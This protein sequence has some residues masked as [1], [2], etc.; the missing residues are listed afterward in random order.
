MS[1]RIIIATL[2][3]ILV[4]SLGYYFLKNNSL[5]T[6]TTENQEQEATEPEELE[7][8]YGDEI[9]DAEPS[10]NSSGYDPSKDIKLSEE[11]SVKSGNEKIIIPDRC[12]NYSIETNNKTVTGFFDDDKVKDAVVLE[13]IDTKTGELTIDA[14]QVPDYKQFIFSRGP[15]RFVTLIPAAKGDEILTQCGKGYKV[16]SKGELKK[17]KLRYDAFIEYNCLFNSSFLYQW[18]SKESKLKVTPLG[19]IGVDD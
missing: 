13:W 8:D 9:E 16:C 5:E 10:D 7:S 2:V 18:N 14:S 11:E 19:E 3:A 17:I 12:V 1:K 6:A 4:I 15:A